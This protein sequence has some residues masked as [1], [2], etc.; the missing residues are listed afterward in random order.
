MERPKALKVSVNG[1]LNQKESMFS[2]MDSDST[3]LLE[4]KV[5]K[6]RQYPDSIAFLKLTKRQ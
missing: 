6:S 5:G 2:T 3:H 1:K 4:R